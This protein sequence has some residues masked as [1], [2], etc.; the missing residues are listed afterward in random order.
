[1]TDELRFPFPTL[2]EAAR[3][4]QELYVANAFI[5]PEDTAES[6]AARLL[7]PLL[8][9][10]EDYRGPDKALKLTLNVRLPA[11]EEER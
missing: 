9:D 8:I 11:P 4:R 10:L 7:A 1:M 6:L 5:R 3:Q 2:E